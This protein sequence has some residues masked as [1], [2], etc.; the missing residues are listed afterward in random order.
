MGKR[1]PRHIDQTDS[2]R[3]KSLLIIGAQSED[4]L[5]LTLRSAFRRARFVPD[6][7]ASDI[8]STD[9][10]VG[11]F[12]S[13]DKPGPHELAARAQAA[14]VS[15]L[16]VHLR[17]NEALIGPL[18]IAGR[19][20]CERC[21]YERMAAAAAAAPFGEG[22]A[23]SHEI[24]RVAGPVLVRDL[25]AI[26][27]RGAEASRLLDHVLF[28]DAGTADESLH[29]VIPLA[30]CVV[31]GGAAAFPKPPQGHVQVSSDDSPEVVLD[32]L[33]GWV[34]LRTG[35]IGGV[36]LE[37]PIEKAFGLPFIAT[38][39]PPHIMEADGSLRRLPLGWGKGLT[40]SGAVLSAA[41]EAMERYSAS[42]PDPAR[43]IWERP[44][45]LDGEFLDPR[46]LA[47]YSDAQYAQD[48]F[49]YTRFNSDVRHPWVLGKWLGSGLPVW[50]P[51]VFA[52]L[53]F[54]VR[55]EHVIGQGTSSGLAAW[56]DP[57]EAARRETMELV[58]R[59]GFLTAWL[60]A[61]PGK[62]I[63]L[64]DSLDASLRR[65]IEGLEA[66]GATVE[67]YILQTSVCGITVLCLGLGGGEE[68]PGATIGL[69]AD[70]D[71]RAALRQAVLELGQTGP[72][73]QRMMRSKALAVPD[74]PSAV[75]EMLQH[76]A[77]YFPR[78]RATAF[79]RLRNHDAPLALRDLLEAASKQS[80]AI[81]ASELNAARV[82][83]ALVD[84]TS[85]D[86]A[87]GPFAVVRAISPDLQPI[88]YGYGLESQ[89]VERVR[90]QG[91]AP[92]IPPI[93]P[94]W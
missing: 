69:G 72:F 25:R 15:L 84:V 55:P 80:L 83:V 89:P 51:A 59:D 50:L 62:R 93:H 76:A 19:A 48:D 57:Q 9:L 30:C 3:A 73:L 16:C 49:P 90:I 14:A 81:C 11:I 20:G 94:I 74:G 41:G 63:E 39:A 79:D 7:N 64:D 29:R 86:V 42:L 36:F 32:L 61:T 40:V 91:L 23:A 70:L 8:H 21:A 38:A 65:V 31:C 82:R 2:R 87:T 78:E 71:S 13:G 52:F 35:V 92:E 58:E 37:P 46:T 18:A 24:A 17:Q 47:I 6:L 53:S 4:A 10:A 77:Y 28:V 68:Y 12:A 43:I 67:V 22:V 66:L 54:T 88:W 33:S 44:D 5:A 34:D 75:R 56:T 1:A 27:R 26:I 60:T 85:A 45:N